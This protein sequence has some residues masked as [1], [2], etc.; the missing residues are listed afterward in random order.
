MEKIRAA[1]LIVSDKG[2]RGLRQDVCAPLLRE[3]L[4]DT[5]QVAAQKILPDERD[6]IA[7]A[8]REW[9]DGGGIDLILT[10]GGTGLSPRDVTPEA[11]MQVGER[12]VPGI[13]EAMRMRSMQA[14]ERAMLSRA[15]AV[16]RGR[17][18]SVNL[19]GSPK[20]VSECMEVLLPVL[21][22]A[23]ETLRGDAS[24]CARGK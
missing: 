17:T 14:T 13:P 7:A 9:C 5:A 4:S 20:A 22:H 11:T 18:L 3:L 15:V 23:V 8:L 2:Y 10:S 21:P 24:D 6:Q 16:I 19:P 12:I 1:I